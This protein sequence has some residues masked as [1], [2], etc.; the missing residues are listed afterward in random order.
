[1]GE[2]ELCEG[3]DEKNAERRMTEITKEIDFMRRF[4]EVFRGR[5][6]GLCHQVP[7]GKLVAYFRWQS[8]LHASDSQVK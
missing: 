8:M 6:D 4:E 7:E 1:M 5:H 2:V 3:V